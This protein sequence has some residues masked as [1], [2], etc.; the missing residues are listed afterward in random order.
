MNYFI[1][2][3]NPKASLPLAGI[4]TRKLTSKPHASLDNGD[5]RIAF[6]KTDVGEFGDFT[7]FQL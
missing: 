4:A 1:G 3:S 2:G 6:E 7:H 5:S